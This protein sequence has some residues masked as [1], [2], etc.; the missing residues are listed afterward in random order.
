MVDGFG[1]INAL[2]T[3][4]EGL[5]SRDLAKGGFAALRHLEAVLRLVQHCESQRRDYS[6]LTDEQL[7]ELADS[8]SDDGLPECPHWSHI[9]GNKI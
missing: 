6:Q 9:R 2:R 7:Q 3:S 8:F 4:W 1:G 5:L